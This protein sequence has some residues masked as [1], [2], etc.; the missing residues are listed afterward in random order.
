[1]WSL[2][3]SFVCPG[4]SLLRSISDTLQTICVD[5]YVLVLPVRTIAGLQISNSRKAGILCIVCFGL[6]SLS[7]S[8]VRFPFVLEMTDAL[9]SLSSTYDMSYNVA[10]MIILVALEMQFAFI[11]LNLPGLTSLLKHHFKQ[12]RTSAKESSGNSIEDQNTISLVALRKRKGSRGQNG[13]GLGTITRL[14]RGMTSVDSEEEL[15]GGE[16]KPSE[17]YYSNDKQGNKLSAPP[18][19]D[20]NK[21]EVTTCVDVVSKYNPEPWARYPGH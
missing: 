11:A 1:M 21:I 20:R 8:A 16:N 18:M 17:R 4:L 9:A 12:I 5:L 15:C 6:A 10:K 13:V 3:F 14:E 7:L 2:L 19:Q